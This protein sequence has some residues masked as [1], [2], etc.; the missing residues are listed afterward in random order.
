MPAKREVALR[1][2]GKTAFGE[3]CLA[4]SEEDVPFRLAGF[5]TVV[6]VEKDLQR[7]RGRPSKLASAGEMSPVT[8]GTKRP[9]LLAVKETEALLRRMANRR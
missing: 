1:F 4:L 8:R 6:L 2:S 9:P 7:L 3:F 5:R